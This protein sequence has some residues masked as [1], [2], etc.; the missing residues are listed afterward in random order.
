MAR[1]IRPTVLWRDTIS[2]H[3]GHQRATLNYAV[4]GA[5]T[6]PLN[7]FTGL[8][9]FSV[10]TAIFLSGA[11]PPG[12]I[13][14]ANSGFQ[15]GDLLALSIGVN[16][17]RGFYQGNPGATIA[18]AQAAA[19]TSVANATANLD[20]LVAARRADDQLVLIQCR[21]DARRVGNQPR[22]P[23]GD[24][25]L[26]QLNTGFQRRSP[27]CRRWLMSHYLEGE[28]CSPYRPNPGAYGI[29]S[30]YCPAAPGP[31]LHRQL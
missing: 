23:L 17:G 31:D 13:F 11:T 6:G 25:L 2:T 26:D 12:T 1:F 20:L 24:A 15:E 21:R 19:V 27:L 18:Q 7:Q 22:P 9:G 3:V 28:W 29:N 4:G 8:P 5:Q 14:P 30:L 16:D 10:E